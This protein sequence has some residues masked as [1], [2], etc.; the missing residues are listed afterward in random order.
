[1][2]IELLKKKPIYRPFLF[3]GMTISQKVEAAR[4]LLPVRNNNID[5][6]CFKSRDKS[7]KASEWRSLVAGEGGERRSSVGKEEEAARMAESHLW[8]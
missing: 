5:A 1:M 4:R 7:A 8:R 6:G 2:Q 3:L